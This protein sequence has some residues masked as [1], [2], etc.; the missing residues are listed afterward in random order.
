[1]YLWD[2]HQ[3]VSSRGTGDSL[4]MFNQRGFNERGY[5]QRCEKN[6]TPTK[7][8]KTVRDSRLATE[9]SN[10]A[11]PTAIR[12]GYRRESNP[13]AFSLPSLSLTAHIQSKVEGK[14]AWVRET[15][16]CYFKPLNMEAAYD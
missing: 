8:G 6:K 5:G 10:I 13:S 11:K 14:E 3:S 1:M 2:V 9:E 4:K 15:S 7:A 16:C 12:R